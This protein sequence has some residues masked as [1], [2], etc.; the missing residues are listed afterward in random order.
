LF[1]IGDIV[2][3]S[4]KFHVRGASTGAVEAITDQ[5]WYQVYWEEDED[6]QI[7]PAFRTYESEL[8]LWQDIL[9]LGGAKKKPII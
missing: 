1:N 2:T 7:T 5:G 4:E 9:A 3:H 6:D 8:T